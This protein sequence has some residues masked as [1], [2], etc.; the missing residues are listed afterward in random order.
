MSKQMNTIF[1]YLVGLAWFAGGFYIFSR[2][3]KRV[4]VYKIDQSEILVHFLK[5]KSLEVRFADISEIRIA[6]WIDLIRFS[7][8]LDRSG[9]FSNALLGKSILIVKKQ[10]WPREIMITPSDPEQFIEE[11][12]ARMPRA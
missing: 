5:S 3:M 7:F 9:H 8:K 4:I 6:N 12:K 1:G 10:G 2:V 11:V